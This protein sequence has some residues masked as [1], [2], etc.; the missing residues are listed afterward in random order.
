MA[1]ADA[2]SLSHTLR[3]QVFAANPLDATTCT[4]SIMILSIDL[5][6]TDRR[7]A[8]IDA[9]YAAHG[10]CCAGCDWWRH[11]NSVVGDC[12]KSAPVAGQERMAMLGIAASSMAPGAGHVMTRRDHHCGEFRDATISS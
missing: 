7:Q 10:P 1:F 4:A 5:Q 12:I 11:Y 9:F 6:R 8:A 2:E 3:G